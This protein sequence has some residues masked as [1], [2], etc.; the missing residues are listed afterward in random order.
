MGAATRCLHLT[1]PDPSFSLT[2]IVQLPHCRYPPNGGRPARVGGTLDPAA[3]EPSRIWNGHPARQWTTTVPGDE[4]R[5]GTVRRAGRTSSARRYLVRTPGQ[6][7]C[8]HQGAS[9]LRQELT[10]GRLGG[11]A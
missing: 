10:G 1:M 2:E 5:A 9:G 6:A 7:T 4:N 3:L 8:S 11:E